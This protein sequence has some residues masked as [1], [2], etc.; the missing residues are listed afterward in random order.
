MNILNVRDLSKAYGPQTLFDSISM[1]VDEGEKVGVIGP[2]GCG[3]STLFQILARTVEA[4]EGIIA[5][6]RGA[7]VGYLAQEPSFAPESSARDVVAAAQKHVRAAIAEY[8]R[9]SHRIATEPEE[10]E[11]LIADQALIGERIERLGGWS[12]E[13]RVDEMLDRLGLS[14][15][16]DKRVAELSGGGRRRVALAAILVEAP[17]LLILDEP[18]N[19]LDAQTVE[20]LEGALRDYRGAL[21]LVTHDRYF[22]D[23]VVTRIIEVD[24]ED[25]FLSYPGNYSIYL[26]RKVERMRMRAKSEDRRVKLLEGE[27]AWLSRGAQARTTKA[28]Y[29]VNAAEELKKEG[30]SASVDN[31]QIEFSAGRRLGGSILS[32]RGISKAY[33]DLQVLDQAQL[34]LNSGEK[35]GIIGPNGCGKST[36][37]KIM[38]GE[39]RQDAGTVEHG[40]NTRTAHLSQARDGLDGEDTVYDAVG[41]SDYV[42]VGE[43]KTHKRSFLAEF[44]F[45]PENQRK[46]I[47]SLS[48]G[49]RCR[50]L[51]AKLVTENANVIALDEPTNDLDIPSL[52]VLESALERFDGC[53]LLVTHDRFFLN[54]V[55]NVIAVVDQGG[56]TRYEG[57]YDF[58]KKRRDEELAEE[59]RSAAETRAASEAN[60][61]AR[62]SDKPRRITFKERAELETIE[63]KILTTE[64]RKQEIEAALSDPTIY[65]AGPERV[66]AL[67]EELG[68]TGTQLESLYER[69]QDLESLAQ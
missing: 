6:R 46:K 14:R 8:E 44:L 12:W 27:M 3:K 57:D 49:E 54:R 4:D 51:L 60:K 52:Q 26:E 20:W 33:G 37:L 31:I 50:V 40:K 45:S 21:L 11:A 66:A 24:R 64:A 55:C 30:P 53:V 41:P 62:P 34:T 39:E 9:L 28:K 68:Q 38:L 59:R 17:D 48:G 67:T 2:N 65:K 36:L 18:T 10:A 13:H 69:W 7:S 58:Y 5:F 1:A 25:G 35:I 61:P 47:L 42:H 32:A 19:H 22:L 23:R 16:I 29:R 63:E 15:D 43:R 56:V